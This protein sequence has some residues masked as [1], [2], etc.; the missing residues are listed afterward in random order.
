[1]DQIPLVV[2]H[3]QMNETSLLVTCIDEETLQV[4][5]GDPVRI[6]SA[7]NAEHSYPALVEQVCL[8]LLAC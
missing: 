2:D 1:M 7:L 5:E 3:Q 8:S 4:S 6:I